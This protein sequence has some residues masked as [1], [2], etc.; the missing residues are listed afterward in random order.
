M[1][2]NTLQNII[3]E[4]VSLHSDLSE[5]EASML[6]TNILSTLENTRKSTKQSKKSDAIKRDITIPFA[7]N[8]DTSEELRGLVNISRNSIQLNFLG[9]STY[10]SE[11][12]KGYPIVIEPE[13]GEVHLL[14]Y[15]E[16]NQPDPTF[17]TKLIEANNENRGDSELEVY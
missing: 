14:V 7:L 15:G 8:K 16:I 11:D 4:I 10:D 12:D 13:M 3:Q 1:N 2:K 6:E 9:H 5:S 17:E